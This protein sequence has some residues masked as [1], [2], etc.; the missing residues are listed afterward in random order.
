MGIFAGSDTR[1][2]RVISIRGPLG[3]QGIRGFKEDTG[4]QSPKCDKDGKGDL[5][6]DGKTAMATESIMAH[7]KIIHL[8]TRID[9]ND[10]LNKSY[11]D[12]Q[13]NNLLKTD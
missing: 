2:N 9:D 11:V 5:G 7:C 3:L 4:P 6:Y 10:A 12:T 1:R 13:T 8:T